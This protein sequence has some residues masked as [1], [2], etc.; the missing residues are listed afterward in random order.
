MLEQIMRG[1]HIPESWRESTTILLLKEGKDQNEIKNY[2]PITL[3][4]VD[5]KIYATILASRLKILLPEIIHKD[6]NG[7]IAGRGLKNNI[8]TLINATEVYHQDP[9]RQAAFVFIDVEKAFDR[10]KW[11]FLIEQLK[12]MEGGKNF[13]HSVK[14]IYSNQQTKILIN[15]DR[16]NLV[17]ISNGTRQGCPLSPLL[18]ILTLE[19]LLIQIRRNIQIKGLKIGKYEYKVQAFADDVLLILE[20][21]MNSIQVTINELEEYGKWAGMRVNKNKTQSLCKNLTQKQKKRTRGK[22]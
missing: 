11:N 22:I 8:R 6:Q 12:Y 1:Q 21:P 4:N 3:L 7:F 2:R 13:I 15:E 9:R 19:P 18:F 16:T 10:V 14:E 20:D 5:Y 17:E